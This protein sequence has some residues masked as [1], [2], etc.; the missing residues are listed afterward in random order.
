MTLLDAQPGRPIRIVQIPDARAR[1]QCIR[2]GIGE[3]SLVESAH[4]IPLGP[5]LVR[6]CEQEICLGR[7]LAASIEIEQPAAPALAR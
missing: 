3:G 1:A 4:K 5:V 2:F 7:R 6:H